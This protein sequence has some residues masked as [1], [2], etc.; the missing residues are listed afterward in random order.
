MDELEVMGAQADFEEAGGL[1]SGDNTAYSVLV[2]RYMQAIQQERG[3]LVLDNAEAAL[4]TACLTGVA[5]TKMS[6]SC[7]HPGRQHHRTD[8]G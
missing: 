7:E 6:S 1:A 4:R 3:G 5:T 8:R 2:S